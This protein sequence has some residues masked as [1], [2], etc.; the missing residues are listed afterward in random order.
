MTAASR[1]GSKATHTSV[2]A[3]T[4]RPSRWCQRE[5]CR[6][7]ARCRCK[8]MPGFPESSGPSLRQLAESCKQI[9]GDNSTRALR[10]GLGPG[11]QNPRPGLCT[12]FG[13]YK[14][15]RPRSEKRTGFLM[16]PVEKVESGLE[17]ELG[18]L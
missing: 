13:L 17:G 14:V 12:C 11:G 16:S 10:R 18:N 15:K 9:L 3:S 5:I 4:H 2:S 1:A 7:T 6:I 8:S